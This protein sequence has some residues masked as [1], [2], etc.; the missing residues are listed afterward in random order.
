MA[1]SAALLGAFFA[2]ELFSTLRHRCGDGCARVS[3]MLQ[4]QSLGGWRPPSLHLQREGGLSSRGCAFC[5]FDER[6]ALLLTA[7]LVASLGCSG[8]ARRARLASEL[9][10]EIAPG[11][12]TLPAAGGRFSL[13]TYLR[14]NGSRA[15]NIC[16]LN[17]GA[18]G[19]T[20]SSGKRWPL[21]MA[22]S[23][24]HAGCGESFRLLPGQ[25]RAFTDECFVWP[26]MRD[27]PGLLDVW[28][29][30][31]IDLNQFYWPGRGQK[32]V[33]TRPVSIQGK[34]STLP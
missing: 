17:E 27:G 7:L 13:T 33:A 32:L 12:L 18:V 15:V 20:D 11:V 9:S 1:V 26:G 6:R 10:L 4:R 29:R 5:R 21:A 19:V 14:N 30:F 22:Y 25:T 8:T 28:L 16:L 2:A 34:P 3:E 23:V 24:T 31:S